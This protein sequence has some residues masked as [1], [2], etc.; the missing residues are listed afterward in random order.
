[1]LRFTPSLTQ[2]MHIGDLQIALLNALVAQWRNEELL[3]R[4]NDINK[5]VLDILDLFGIKYA[6][7]VHQ[8]QNFRFYSAMA[9]DLL[10]KKK[11]FSCFCSDEWIAKK[12]EEAQKLQEVY[13]YDD[14]CRN[15]PAELVIDNTAPFC[16][17]IVRPEQDISMVDKQ[18]GT[19]LIPHSTI[20]SFIIMN[21]DKTPTTTF[22]SAVDDMLQDIEFVV[23]SQSS[24]EETPKEIY[25]R[26]Q[27][28][29]EKVLEYLHIPEVIDGETLSIKSLLEEG[30]L[31]EAISN[32][33]LNLSFEISQDIFTFQEAVTLLNFDTLRQVPQ[34]FDKEKLRFFNREYLKKMD[35][36]ELSRYVGFADAEIGELARVFL[37][38]VTTTKELKAKLEP[39]F[40]PKHISEVYMQDAQSIVA[41]VKEA[42]YFDEY[43]A[44]CHYIVK[45]TGIDTHRVGKIISVLLTNTDDDTKIT[46]I[47]KYLKNYIGELIK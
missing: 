31:P 34:R 8:N 39:I 36:K 16:I 21:Q 38:D 7:V 30:F 1:M 43:D 3:I 2:D 22:A 5:D 47:Y 45:H 18:K 46:E 32:Y 11:A 42:P 12:K 44:F 27:L 15:L 20:D 40:A 33:L 28:G 9:L 24:L 17:R 26:Q 4:M 19:L 37:Q 35:P 29:Y 41:C 14:A 6:Q 10:H 25:I 23:V 13:Q